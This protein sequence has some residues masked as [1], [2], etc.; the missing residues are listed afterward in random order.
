[1]G[2]ENFWRPGICFDIGAATLAKAINRLAQGV[3]LKWQE[4]QPVTLTEWFPDADCTATVYS[5]NKLVQERYLVTNKYPHHHA[6]PIRF[7]CF[8]LSGIIRFAIV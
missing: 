5:I 4:E 1:M 7:A 3:E 8:L 6:Y 2:R